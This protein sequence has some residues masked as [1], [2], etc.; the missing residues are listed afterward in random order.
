MTH[1]PPRGPAARRAHLTLVVLESREGPSTLTG[2][3]GTDLFGQVPGGPPPAGGPIPG[4]GQPL[5]NRPPV[6]TGFSAIVGPNGRVTF[7]GT[8][9][10]DQPVAGL[11]VII[12]GGGVTA[13][14]IVGDDGTFRV[15]TTA[16]GTVPITVTAT[17]T[18]TLG[19]TSDPA[20]TT[21]TPTP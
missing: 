2:L 1:P 7:A 4:V 10:D 17:V 20:Q 9:T 6:I 15:T 19:A 18:D 5:Q 12:S 14:A 11:V 13:T 21:F 3:G 16:A 8:V